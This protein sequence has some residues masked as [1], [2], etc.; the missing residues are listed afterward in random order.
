MALLG[1]IEQGTRRLLESLVWDNAVWV[2][3]SSKPRTQLSVNGRELCAQTPCRRQV[4]PG[5]HRLSWS[6][7]GYG[8]IIEDI[9]L[10]DGAELFRKLNPEV[11]TVI[12]TDIPDGVLLALDGIAW[13][14]SPINDTVSAG[15]HTIQVIDP[16]YQEQSLSFDAKVGS[17]VLNLPVTPLTTS[18]RFKALAPDGR[19]T[20]ARVLADGEWVG[21]S[22][23]WLQIPSCT[24]RLELHSEDARW[25][26]VVDLNAGKRN[27][28]TVQLEPKRETVG[29]EL[30]TI[31]LGSFLMGSPPDEQGRSRD[32]LQHPVEISRPFA[33][34]VSE[35][36]QRLWEDVMGNNPAHHQRCGQRCPVEQ[37][38]WCDALIFANRLSQQEGLEQ[39]YQLP[40]G[41]VAELDAQ[42]CNRLST[43]VSLDL[44]ADGYRLP[45]EAE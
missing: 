4:V 16:C 45:T 33:I 43:M 24:K 29:L 44:T 31:G 11:S 27:R 14:R 41:F 12:I 21:Q 13:K 6:R 22:G 19:S 38:S 35:V 3:F 1:E 25:D 15:A 28:H 37:V 36:S 40:M 23:S 7:E 30:R 26:G 5:L 8:T 20:D 42:A 2:S 18:V 17:T 10:E 39:V 34:G 32:E 9:K